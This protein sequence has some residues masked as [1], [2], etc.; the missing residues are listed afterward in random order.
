MR[1]SMFISVALMVLGGVVYV[2]YGLS[3]PSGPNDTVTLVFSGAE[4][5]YL[6]PCGCSE[7][8]LGGIARRD[9]FLQQFR[10]NG[11]V[12]V[13]IA[14]GNLIQNISPQSEIKADIGFFALADMGYIAY[15]IGERDLL[16]G[17]A[18]LTAFSAQNQI[19]LI[20]ANLYQGTSPAFTP[21][22]WHTVQL[23]NDVVKIAIIGLIS[24][25]YAI[26]AENT[27]L[28]ILDPTTVLNNVSLINKGLFFV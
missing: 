9:S 5:G 21:Y 19:P 4:L 11:N 26:Y 15:N 14:N 22:L 10:S 1:S 17:T 8:Q 6:E 12:I 18:Q 7:G 16:L 20:S 28:R 23:P 24:P 2:C 27:D 13:P 3:K 25:S